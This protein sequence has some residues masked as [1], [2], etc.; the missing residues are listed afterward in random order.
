M[1]YLILVTALV[2]AALAVFIGLPSPNTYQGER[3]FYQILV[4]VSTIILL[5]VEG[6]V[7]LLLHIR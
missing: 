6:L 5:L 2:G 7:W 4:A 3:S 1:G